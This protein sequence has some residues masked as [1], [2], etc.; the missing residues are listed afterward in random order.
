MAPIAS[1][2]WN[3]TPSLR[4]TITSMGTAKAWATS[5]A[6]GTPPCGRAKTTAS[7][8][9]KNLSRA[10]KRRPASR[11]SAN[12]IITSSYLRLA[13]FAG[14]PVEAKVSKECCQ[15]GYPVGVSASAPRF[16]G[17]SLRPG[18]KGIPD[19]QQYARLFRSP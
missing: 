18:V 14:L 8:P 19:G 4:T 7:S 17:S 2:G 10:A 6:T 5:N 13:Q 15:G 3:G 11:R 16:W 12:D 1:S 9:R